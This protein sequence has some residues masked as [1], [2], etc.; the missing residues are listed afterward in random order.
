MSNTLTKAVVY[1]TLLDEVI[2]AGLTSA[3]LT[4]GSSRVKY[5]GGN[6]VKIAK[7]SV[8]GYGTYD[9]ATGYPA[10]AAT[11]SWE[12][13]VITM[14]RGI[15]FNVDVMDE[16][17][18]MQTLS[19]ANIITEFARSQAIPEIDSYRYSAIFDAIVD[20]ATVKY[21]YY[22]PAEATIL[23]TIQGQIAD[24]QNLIGEQ[25]PMTCYISGAAFKYLT[26][27]T[28]LAKQ[29]GV[30][31]VT[32]ANGITTKIY[33]IDGVP[34]VVVP[35]ARMKTEYAFSATNGFA[36]KDFAQDINWIL[37]ADSA[38][39]AF[40]KHQ[41]TKIVSADD[42]QTADAE[43]VMAREYHD[44]WV[45]ENK[46]NAIYVSL[47]T[48][49]IAGFG[50]GIIASTGATDA[51][52]TLGALYTNKDTGHEFYY[53]DGGSATEL[54]AVACYDDLTLAGWVKIESA[55]KAT[56]VTTSKYFNYLVELDENGRVIR[57][58]VLQTA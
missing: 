44:C 20:D 2:T 53:L 1:N 22:T 52:Y 35:S 14:D 19:V 32:G 26:Q 36:A 5:N 31:S 37:I 27:S 10:G 7:L 8:G 33:D 17:E 47:K 57:R 48:A 49:T 34:L 45:Y 38:A 55:A 54:A 21:G 11:Q 29:L 28:Q 30:Q 13:H 18:T 40:V 41:K 16:D 51:N 56:D 23:G 3:K 24:I 43:K 50:S 42:N 15:T 4:A 39:V 25:E 46:H 6:T 12:D 9:R 58:S